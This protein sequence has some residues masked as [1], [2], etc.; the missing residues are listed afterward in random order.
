MQMTKG[1][2]IVIV[3][4]L[5]SLVSGGYAAYQTFGAE[6][7]R[8]GQWVY[9][10]KLCMEYIRGDEWIAKNCR[11]EDWEGEFQLVCN[12]TIDDKTYRGSLSLINMSKAEECIRYSDVTSVYIKQQEGIE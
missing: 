11:A 12:V 8:K 6:P 7:L 1:E 2:I 4:L 9:I 5:V 10:G 3:L